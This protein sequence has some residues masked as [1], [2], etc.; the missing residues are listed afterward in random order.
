MVEKKRKKPIEV[1]RAEQKRF[2]V[3]LSRPSRGLQHHLV[4]QVEPMILTFQIV[5]VDD[6]FWLSKISFDLNSNLILKMMNWSDG[7]N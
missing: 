7:G 4:V 2:Q 6:Q 5:S 3:E 1:N